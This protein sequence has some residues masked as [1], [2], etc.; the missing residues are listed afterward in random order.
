MSCLSLFLR[1]FT[2][3]KVYQVS[4]VVSV[5]YTYMPMY[6]LIVMYGLRTT[7]DCLHVDF[8]VHRFVASGF[9][10]SYNI[11]VLSGLFLIVYRM[12]TVIIFV[13]SSKNSEP[14]FTLVVVSVSYKP[15]YGLI[16]MY[17]LR[18]FISVL[19]ELQYLPTIDHA[20]APIVIDFTQFTTCKCHVLFHSALLDTCM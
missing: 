7:M 8:I 4:L 10:V 17:G 9:R 15:I 20:K 2:V 5:S 19:Q 3:K 1:M 12:F 11:S 16:V 18:L 13:H 6:G 14:S